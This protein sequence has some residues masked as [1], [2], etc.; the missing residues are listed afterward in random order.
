MAVPSSGAVAFST[1]N[2]VFGYGGAMS[3]YVGK[4]YYWYD[5]NWGV[6]SAQFPGSNFPMTMFYGTSGHD[7][8]NCACDCNC[9]CGK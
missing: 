1:V 5:P 7:E 4:Y 8:W 3:S 6:R 2:S 9:A